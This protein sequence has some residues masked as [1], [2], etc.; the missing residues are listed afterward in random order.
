MEVFCIPI[1]S[2]FFGGGVTVHPDR[3]FMNA[4]RA[5]KEEGEESVTTERKR[6]RARERERIHSRL[7]HKSKTN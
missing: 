1:C 6:E 4:R 7:H 5:D 3:L 2:G